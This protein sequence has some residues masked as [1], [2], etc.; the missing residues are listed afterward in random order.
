MTF[1]FLKK[2]LALLISPW[3]LTAVILI[4]LAVGESMVEQQERYNAEVLAKIQR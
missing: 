3:F 4:V 1:S 2:M